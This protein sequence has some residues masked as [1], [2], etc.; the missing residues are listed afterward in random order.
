MF[1]EVRFPPNIARRRSPLQ[2]PRADRQLVPQPAQKPTENGPLRTLGAGFGKSGARPHLPERS[3]LKIVGPVINRVE[4]GQKVSVIADLAVRR[5]GCWNK[6]PLLR[7]AN[8]PL[9]LDRKVP[10]ALPVWKRISIGNAS[11][12]QGDDPPDHNQVAATVC[13]LVGRLTAI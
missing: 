1:G 8:D 11:S 4:H 12:V 2:R 9:D 3:R 5:A 7:S 6:R 13:K 10:L